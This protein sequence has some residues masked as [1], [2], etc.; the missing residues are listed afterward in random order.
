M[1]T[2]QGDALRLDLMDDGRIVVRATYLGPGGET[3]ASQDLLIEVVNLPPVWETGC[4]DTWLSATDVRSDTV[5]YSAEGGPPG[6]LVTADGHVTYL[7]VSEDIGTWDV[8]GI[9]SDEDGGVATQEITVEVAEQTP[10]CQGTSS[11]GCC[12]GGGG[13]ALLMAGG[14]ALRRRRVLW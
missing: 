11:G 10:A 9:A 4:N 3:I 7:A 6:L 13:S 14:L 2:D 5:S 1:A 8:T 12:C